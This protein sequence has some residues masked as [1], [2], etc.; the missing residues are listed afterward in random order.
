[1]PITNVL[2][3]LMTAGIYLHGGWRKKRLLDEEEE[4]TGRVSE[5]ILFGEGRR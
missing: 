5:E 4:L 3:T 1:L 2:I